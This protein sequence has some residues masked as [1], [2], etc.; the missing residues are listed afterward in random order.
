MKKWKEA[1]LNEA[2]R[3]I[4]GMDSSARFLENLKR[5]N[6]HHDY[7]HQSIMEKTDRE[8]RAIENPPSFS[9]CWVEMGSGGRQERTVW[10]DQDNGI[11]YRCK[12]QDQP[13]V[14]AY[15]TKL[16][17]KVVNMLEVVGYPKCDGLIMATNSRWLQSV[18]GWKK[19]WEK[20]SEELSLDTIRYLL[21]SSDLRAIYGDD[22][23]VQELCSWWEQQ[24][25]S[26][27]L[28]QRL[29][30][31]SLHQR[32]PIGFFG[33][34]FTKTHGEYAGMFHLKEGGY[35][36]L[37]SMIRVLSLRVGIFPTSTQARISRL[38]QHSY[39]TPLELQ[40]W[41]EALAF[42]L[43]LRLKNHVYLLSKGEGLHDY[44]QLDD[45]SKGEISALKHH[46]VFLK[47]QQKHW[48]KVFDKEG[49]LYA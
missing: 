44:I 38:A 47:K 21:I 39:F 1:I 24:N 8:L 18:E 28:R 14:I 41:E 25:G 29:V 10:S 31:Y 46:L 2:L 33:Q 16:A 45:L 4:E 48:L 5:I 30:P 26:T 40:E 17:E 11:V 22:G 3:A 15:L 23:L 43:R 35:Y 19:N 6:R 27:S 9:Y 32:I 37:I 36:P 49:G 12:E 34:L 20:W 42:Y 13:A 7:I